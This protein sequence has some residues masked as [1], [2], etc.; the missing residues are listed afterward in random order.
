[1]EISRN[2]HFVLKAEEGFGGV[3]KG[4][5]KVLELLDTVGADIIDYFTRGITEDKAQIIREGEW[6]RFTYDDED[7]L[8]RNILPMYVFK[9]LITD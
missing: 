8:V 3:R 2:M 9:E 5:V 4:K 1:M 6:V 7:D